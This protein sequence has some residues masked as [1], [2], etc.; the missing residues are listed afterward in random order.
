MILI[1]RA[2]AQGSSVLIMNELT[3][4]LDYSNQARILHTTRI[5]ARQGV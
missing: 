2:L 4:D 1:A 5:L 3:A